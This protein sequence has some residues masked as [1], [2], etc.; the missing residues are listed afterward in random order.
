MPVANSI[1]IWGAVAGAI[2]KY[3][4]WRA[5]EEKRKRERAEELRA[6]IVNVCETFTNSPAYRASRDD[7]TRE[8]ASTLLNQEFS[9]RA[10]SFVDSKVYESERKAFHADIARLSEDIKEN[11]RTLAEISGK[12]S[13]IVVK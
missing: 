3:S 9:N 1:V 5:T 4:T 11:T 12:L 13:T 10:S 7:R 2:I 8:V 6:L